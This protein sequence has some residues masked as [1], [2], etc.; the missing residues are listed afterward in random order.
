MLRVIR[1]L[2]AL[3]MLAGAVVGLPL[4]LL[5]VGVPLVP[6]GVSWASI[7][8]L[9]LSPDNTGAAL[10][11]LVTVAAW[12][13]WA[14]FTVMVV[15]ELVRLA[16]GQ[17]IRWHLP[18]LGGAQQLVGALL[19]AVITIAG[20]PS[21]GMATPASGTPAAAAHQTH[22]KPRPGVDYTVR[23]G[24]S[25][26][27]IAKDAY[28]D[29]D[30]YPVIAKANKI[31]S[32]AP[33]RP[34]QKL[35]IP[36]LAKQPSAT[37]SSPTRIRVVSGDTLTSLAD[38]HL[39][40]S[41]RWPELYQANKKVI[42]SDPD[43]LEVGQV[44]TI[45]AT[46]APQ[47][48]HQKPSPPK[49]GQE[50]TGQASQH[51]G[52]GDTTKASQDSISS[53]QQA[54]PAQPI[55]TQPTPATQP[56][57]SVQQDQAPEQQSTTAAA[58]GDIAQ[59]GI[60]AGA[61]LLLATSLIATIGRRRRRQL[62]ERQ[63]GE[64][65]TLPDEAAQRLETRA[66]T[67]AAPLTVERLDLV[68]RGIAQHCLD[69]DLPLPVLSA[70]RVAADR[71]DLLLSE[72]AT[73]H[74][75]WVDL[76]ADGSVWTIM[77]G[78]SDHLPFLVEDLSAVAAPYP[79]VVSIGHDD[80]QALILIDLETAG[81]LTIATTDETE[82]DSAIRAIALELAIGPFAQDLNLTLVGDVCPGLETALTEPTVTRV[83]DVDEL[84]ASLTERAQQQRDQMAGTRTTA[85][86]NR[87]DPAAA[88]GWDPEIVLVDHA[89]TPEQIGQLATVLTELPRVAIAAVTTVDQDLSPWRLNVGGSPRTAVLDPHNW[90]L[91]PLFVSARDYENVLELLS[92]SRTGTTQPATWWDQDATTELEAIA[93]EDSDDEIPSEWDE[94]APTITVLK[95][96]SRPAVTR[97]PLSLA[98]AE[99]HY[100]EQRAWVEQNVGDDSGDGEEDLSTTAEPA[101]AE[102]THLPPLAVMH[103]TPT[104]TERY[105]L[106]AITNPLAGQKAPLLKILGAVELLNTATE[107]PARSKRRC[108]ETLLYMIEHPGCSTADIANA[109]V[110]APNSVKQNVSYLRTWLG[111]DD[112]GDAYLPNG[113]GGYRPNPLITTDWHVAEALFTGGVNRA[114]TDNLV[115][116]LNLITG[117]PFEGVTTGAFAYAEPLRMRIIQALTD[118]ALAL[119]DRALDTND[120][121]LARWATG[122]AMTLDPHSEALA[123]ARIRTEYQAGNVSEVDRLQRQL[124]ATARANATDLCPE[125]EEVLRRVAT[126]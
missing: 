103:H 90:S 32:H 17:R 118:A 71:I 93:A 19:I 4:L 36:A 38:E 34:G 3:L 63:R 54:E 28:G 55:E 94:P 110:I 16:S 7:R 45:P 99:A 11:W 66:R 115:S 33:I 62:R 44:L 68:L 61:G 88:D 23:S 122:K 40:D 13:A 67:Q 104:A 83:A 35:T 29:G 12:V 43:A 27:Q 22:A 18:A 75:E 107:A 95:P 125:T 117:A 97:R 120:L 41:E 85:G 77:S 42:G 96:T 39:G 102:P 121:D 64:S 30:Q 79:A 10:M 100:A 5:S 37:Q 57:S 48:Q 114:S 52:S 15:L 24:D 92:T 60:L 2:A 69:Q 74:P 25:L 108:Q 84:L 21:V 76:V 20:A 112:N 9:L 47:T 78:R 124:H 86:Q 105:D 50:K 65:I 89:L 80:D 26:W 56:T 123:T 126:R 116:A 31:P 91:N 113:I 119:T 53:Q 109:F 59:E 6:A 51:H 87:V 14:L 111:N 8:Q 72:P 46:A 70:V 1:G 73:H 58:D 49:T 101:L 81:A 82:A 98:A 106:E